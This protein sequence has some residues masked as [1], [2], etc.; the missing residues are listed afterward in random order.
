MFEKM[1]QG[2]TSNTDVYS[3]SAKTEAGVYRSFIFQFCQEDLARLFL[4]LYFFS[5]LHML[6]CV[7]LQ[8]LSP[9]LLPWLVSAEVA[10][11]VIASIS[12]SD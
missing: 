8:L 1:L 3:C 9:V 7:L 4:S 10:Q 5:S 12:H 2:N 6:A 11:C